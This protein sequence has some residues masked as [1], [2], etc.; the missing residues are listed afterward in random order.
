MNKVL[1]LPI[2]LFMTGCA[3]ID[4]TISLPE[5][6]AV[7]DNPVLDEDD[8]PCL[9]SKETAKF[10]HQCELNYWISLW[11]H[12]EATRWPERKK[13]ISALGSSLPDMIRKIVLAL[14][15][16]TPYQD[17][18]RA[19]HWLTSVKD[20]LTP[21][22]QQVVQTL[23]ISPNDEM[24]ELESAMTILNRVNSDQTQSLQALHAE[25]EAQRK[26]MQELLEVEAT[27][28]DKNRSSQQ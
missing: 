3:A 19:Q 12:A 25:L 2:I 4:K 16:D 20:K 7:S 24:L 13:A 18:L 6:P 11:V 9:V 26:K 5:T 17:R 14:P 22:M 8:M 10:D 28:M 21:Q 23:V 1:L 27:L 15:V